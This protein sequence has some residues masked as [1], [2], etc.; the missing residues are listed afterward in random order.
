MSEMQSAP[1]NRFTDIV[2]KLGLAVIVAMGALI[3]GGALL[4]SVVSIVATGAIDL[5]H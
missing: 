4:L 3:I 5:G 2:G 1:R